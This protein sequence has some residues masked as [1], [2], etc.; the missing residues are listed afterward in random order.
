MD[1]QVKRKRA[2]AART[3][4]TKPAAVVAVL[5]S[6]VTR[7]GREFW[8]VKLADGSEKKLYTSRSSL[9]AMDEALKLYPNALRRLADR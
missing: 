6:G 7:S 5:G 3:R 2:K 4:P 1:Q 9:A 8:R